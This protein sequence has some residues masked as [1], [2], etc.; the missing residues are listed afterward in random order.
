M[1]E[2]LIAQLKWSSI[3]YRRYASEAIGG[4]IALTATFYGLFLSAS[5]IGGGSV[6]FGDRLD[7][8]IVG[9]VLWSLVI[10]IMGGI[11]G[12]LQRE[13]QVGTLEQLF[14]SPFNATQILLFRAIGDLIIQTFLISIVLIIIMVTTGRWLSFSPALILPFITVV[15]GAYGIAFAAGGLALI[16]KSIQQLLGIFNF[17]LLFLLTIPTETWSGTQQVL[18]WILPM[19]TGAGL[20][21]D[22]MARSQPLALPLLGLALLNG[23]VYFAL[24]VSLFRWAERAAKRRGKLAGY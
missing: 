15:L 2:L 14:I 7:S 5:Y 11:P 24:G 19:T 21:R 22:L 13:A 3:Q 18:G 16:F 23:L 6:R 20:L 8:V 17:A 9:Y 12:T 4:V 1:L 10:F